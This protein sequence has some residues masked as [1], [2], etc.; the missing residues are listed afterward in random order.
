MKL[1]RF[2]SK[3]EFEKLVNGEK[4]INKKKH[5]GRTGST[6]FCFMQYKEDENIRYSYEYLSGVVTNDI[7][8]VFETNK[9]N[10]KESWGIYADPNGSFFDTITETEYCTTQYDKDTFKI[11][12]YGVNVKEYGL[13]IKW[14]D[15]VK[16][17]LDLINKK[18]KKAKE[19]QKEIEKKCNCVKEIKLEKAQELQEFID[20]MKNL[21]KD[22]E[23]KINGKYYKVNGNL[24]EIEGDTYS[25]R[26][27][28]D[29]YFRR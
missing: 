3:K 6:G 17:A 4:L 10:V 25:I 23:L 22:L 27:N 1:F 29:I 5:K 28:F 13:D 20:D 14:Y 16:K 7:I 18:I 9:K 2:M 21:S 24:N 26:L 15:S 19:K 8:V 12:K 11:V